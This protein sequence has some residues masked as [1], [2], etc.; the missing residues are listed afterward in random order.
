MTIKPKFDNEE[1][2]GSSE[3]SQTLHSEERV[4]EC[5]IPVRK[6][7]LFTIEVDFKSVPMRAYCIGLTVD[8][9]DRG[10]W[11][12]SSSKRLLEDAS[13]AIQHIYCQRPRLK[14]QKPLKT[15]K[16]WPVQARMCFK[17]L[18]SQMEANVRQD[19]KVPLP[20]RIEIAVWL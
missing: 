15:K 12:K 13:L 9:V 6:K 3:F 16:R 20:G 1:I 7:G 11:T 8:G 14:G 4:L 18:P 17:A 5:F 10:Y 2:Y 19:R